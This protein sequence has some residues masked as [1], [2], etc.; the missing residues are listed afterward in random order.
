MADAHVI[1]FQTEHQPPPHTPLLDDDDDTNNK[2][3][4]SK[5]TPNHNPQ[6][7]NQGISFPN[8]NINQALEKLEAYLSFLGFNQSSLKSFLLSWA[9][10]LLVGVLL[11][12][13]LLELSQCSGCDK[14]QIKDF[15][16][17]IVA[18]QACLAAVSLICLSH[19]LRKYGIRKFLFVDR[20][21]GHISRFSLLYIRQIKV[22][23]SLN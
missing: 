15:E 8:Q 5:S 1:H 17:D 19:N 21:G 14:Y 12:V 7:Q 23:S 2:N 10:F 9:A 6:Q 4:N 16:L 18:S 11:P 13:A 22:I 3:S 20:F